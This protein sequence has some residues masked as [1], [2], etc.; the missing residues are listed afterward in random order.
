MTH[1]T[2]LH[3]PSSVLV[4]GAGFL[5][6]HITHGFVARGV[7]TRVL[8]RQPV[9]P[10]TAERLAGSELVFGDAGDVETLRVALGGV[11][12]VVWCVGGLLPADSNAD[13]VRDAA[14]ALPPLLHALELLSDEGGR[15]FTLISSGGTVYG[16]PSVLPVPEHHVLQPITSHGVM[17]VT[18]E[19]YVA[20]S[21][22]LH[23]LRAVALRCANVYGEGQRPDRSQGLVATAF[24]RVRRGVPI[25]IFG[26]GS[27][28]RDYVHVDDVVDVVCTLSGRIDAPAVVNLG[29]GRGTSV[30]ELLASVERVVGR[31]VHVEHQPSRPGDARSIVLDVTLLRSLLAFEPTSLDVGLAR[32]WS[33]LLRVT[34]RVVA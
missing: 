11:E 10:L 26:D 27:A 22:E 12:H 19:M 13:A 21:S 15:S 20:L 16:N 25:T 4:V 5:G 14:T 33:Q 34:P 18:S 32:T 30:I 29:T 28:V 3:V 7:A 24:D 31:A 2:R 9:D 6:S 8:T 23:G 1:S 17:K